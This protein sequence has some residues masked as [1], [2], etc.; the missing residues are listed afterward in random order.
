MRRWS[1]PWMMMFDA[2]EAV[3]NAEAGHAALT[4]QFA[5][6]ADPTAEGIRLDA[7]YIIATLRRR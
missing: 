7:A 4:D 3:G 1:G 6:Y 5:G 2:L